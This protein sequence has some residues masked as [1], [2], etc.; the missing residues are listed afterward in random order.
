V[1]CKGYDE[2]PK[3]PAMRIYTI[4]RDPLD[5]PGKFVVRGFSIVRGEPSPVPDAKGYAVDSLEHARAL[6]PRGTFRIGP[7]T[8]DHGTI[9]ESWV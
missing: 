9:V 3:V 2:R 8:E 6:V 5:A 1:P 4:F 7:S